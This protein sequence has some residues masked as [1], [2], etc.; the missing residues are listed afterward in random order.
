VTRNVDEGFVVRSWPAPPHENPFIDII[1]DLIFSEGEKVV[2][3][4]PTS[5]RTVLRKQNLYIIHWPDEL[6]WRFRSKRRLWLDIFKVLLNLSLLRIRGTKI[7]WFV[8]NLEP[9]DLKA[10]LKSAWYVLAN[11]LCCITNGWISLSPSTCT[12]V[13]VRY[14]LLRKKPH[15][16]IWHPLYPAHYQ[17]TNAVARTELEI[18]DNTVVF[19]HVGGLRPS[20]GLVE[21]ANDFDMFSPSKALLILAGKPMK[22]VDEALLRI[23][24][25]STSFQYLP[26]RLAA[27][28]F[29]RIL[30]ATDV[31]IAPYADFLHSGALIHALS[32]SCVIVAPQKPFVEDLER[33]VGSDWVVSYQGSLDARTL[34][35]AAEAAQRV[36]GQK[37]CLN[38]I[39][40]S[41]NR[42]R[43]RSLF[44]DLGITQGSSA[45]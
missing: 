4:K 29:D 7:V 14:P 5:W 9:H 42:L 41:E 21:L 25:I 24:G 43:A 35:K 33:V 11:G 3:A 16:Y 36:K 26:G 22:E 17:G 27:R 13:T 32:R 37:P 30:T 20:K 10:D 31:F 40:S 23:S 1:T 28:D 19:A 34:L 45:K 2:S 39:T 44:T 12:P 38:E 6:F 18:A 15:T 8:H